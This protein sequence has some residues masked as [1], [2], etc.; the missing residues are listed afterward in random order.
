ML[1]FLK[2]KTVCAGLLAGGT[3]IIHTLA[4]LATAGVFGEK[5]RGIVTGLAIVLG[6]VGIKDAIVKAGIPR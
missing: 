1:R 4:P 2:S 5:V 6:T 3:H